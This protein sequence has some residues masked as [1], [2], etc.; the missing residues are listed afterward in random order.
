MRASSSLRTLSLLA[1]WLLVSGCPS[2][3]GPETGADGTTSST[4]SSAERQ[5]PF[6]EIDWP[7]DKSAHN[8][9]RLDV[10]GRAQEYDVVFVN[11]DRVEVAED[12]TWVVDLELSE[13]EGEIRVVAPPVEGQEPTV[14]D[15]IQ[16]AVDLRAPLLQLSELPGNPHPTQQHVQ[17]VGA[18]A[19]LV[20]FVQDEWPG[21]IAELTLDG[22]AQTIEDGDFRAPLQLTEDGPHQAELVLRDAAGNKTRLKVA[23]VRDTVAPQVRIDENLAQAGRDE[24]MIRGEIVDANPLALWVDGQ[25]VQIDRGG[26]FEVEL[27]I[28]GGG[29]LQFV[30]EDAAGNVSDDVFV[31]A[32]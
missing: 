10:R 28:P 8:T 31:E 25:K 14:L 4:E 32:H 13:G 27:A 20:G 26:G 1:G 21:T 5:G 2:S 15:S 9:V 3:G 16:V 17:V 18:E 19:E 6:A 22:V 7:A 23:F 30:A 11:S 12:G 29:S 24:R